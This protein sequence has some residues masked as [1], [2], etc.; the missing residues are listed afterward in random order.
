[1]KLDISADIRETEDEKKVEK[2]VKNL[3]PSA[4]LDKKDG[5]ITASSENI[6]DLDYLRELIIGQ[7]INDTARAF[8][9][10]KK[11]ESSICFELNKQAA[12]MSKVNFVD[13]NMALGTIKIC[14][15]GSSQEL[16][17]ILDYLCSA[18]A[19]V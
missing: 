14:L 18:S 15:E 5:T 10:S 2:A 1:M 9:S 12:Y 13:F 3:F 17:R 7:Q 4:A 6:S 8:L 11:N 16:D 19:D